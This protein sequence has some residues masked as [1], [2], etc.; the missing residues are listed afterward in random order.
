MKPY[1]ISRS[2]EPIWTTP[3]GVHEGDGQILYA[4]CDVC[5]EPVT[6]YVVSGPGAELRGDARFIPPAEI[7]ALP[8]EHRSTDVE[9]GGT[10]VTMGIATAPGESAAPFPG[11]VIHGYDPSKTYS[12]PVALPSTP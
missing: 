6:R 5:G 2:G 9:P 1:S 12:P 10:V 3:N 8:C 11:V 4:W 7:S